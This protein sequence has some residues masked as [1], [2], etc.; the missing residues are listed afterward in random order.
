M[1]RISSYFFI[2][3]NEQGYESVYKRIRLMPL[4]SFPHYK[5]LKPHLKNLVPKVFLYI[6]FDAFCAQVDKRDNPSLNGDCCNRR[7]HQWHRFDL[8]HK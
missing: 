3:R 1:V 6:V 4:Y 7:W 5:E 2:P 8:L